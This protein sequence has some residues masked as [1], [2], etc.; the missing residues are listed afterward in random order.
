MGLRRAFFSQ[1]APYIIRRSPRERDMALEDA[2]QAP[3]NALAQF[4]ESG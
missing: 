1:I 2:R 4:G 3:F